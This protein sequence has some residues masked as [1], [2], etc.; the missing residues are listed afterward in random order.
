MGGTENPVIMSL[1][2]AHPGNPFPVLKSGP[3]QPRLRLTA[4]RVGQAVTV[5]REQIALTMY[6][7]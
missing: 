7:D 2:D 3:L 5:A 4:A 1:R 6:R